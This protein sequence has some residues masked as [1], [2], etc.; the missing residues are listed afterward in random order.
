[1]SWMVCSDG[2]DRG[3]GDEDEDFSA[4]W[5]STDAEAGQNPRPRTFIDSVADSVGTSAHPPRQTG[6]AP[7]AVLSAKWC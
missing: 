1:M 6:A 7:T 5:A 4:A 2:G 3:V